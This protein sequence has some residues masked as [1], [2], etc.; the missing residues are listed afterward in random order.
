MDKE[1]AIKQPSSVR[2]APGS[3][4]PSASVSSGSPLPEMAVP[5]AS[6]KAALMV[7][8][9]ALLVMLWA[10]WPVLVEV[11]D[12]W[13]N[14][15]LYSHG[16]L[17]PIFALFLLCYRRA[18][19][20]RA[21]QTPG[22]VGW[23]KFAV[24][25]TKRTVQALVNLQPR[26]SWWALPFLVVGSVMLLGAAYFYF[27]WPDRASLLFML[28]AV[29]LGVWG[30]EA[31]KWMWPSILF[32]WFMLPF[33]GFIE[34]GIRYPLRRVATIASTSVLQ[35]FGIFAYADGNVIALPQ[36][37]PL[38][39]ADACSGLNTVSVFFALTVGVSFVLRRPLWQK[40]VILLS[41]LP[42]AV[43]CNV[44]RITATGVFCELASPELVREHR[45]EFHDWA[46][47]AMPPIAL[48]LLLLEIKVLDFIYEIEPEPAPTK[49]RPVRVTPHP[50]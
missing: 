14:N 16:Y 45:V 20:P 44:I 23:T 36:G 38:E 11:A 24:E 33:P 9:L 31:L 28:V 43:L 12:G 41:S 8:A 48:L 27:S 50:S 15:P 30:W 29:V 10:Y 2:P 6:G 26:P 49:A 22:L 4:A 47:L 42:I 5:A 37:E 32:L 18:K 13:A 3:R 40:V 46:G 25:E 35:T 39:V 19:P 1:T 34:S 21:E 17:V 7:A